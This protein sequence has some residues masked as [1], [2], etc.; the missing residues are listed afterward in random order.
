LKETLGII[1]DGDGKLINIKSL[2]ILS[3]NQLCWLCVG[4]QLMDPFMMI[5]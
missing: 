4:I 3:P 2:L 5:S 1:A